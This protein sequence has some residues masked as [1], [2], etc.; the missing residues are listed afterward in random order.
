[1]AASTTADLVIESVVRGHHVYKQ[2]WTPLVG[3]ELTLEREH[4]NIHDCYATTVIKDTMI[5]GRVP[6]QL[7]KAFWNFLAGG[8]LITCEVTGPRKKGKGLEVPCFYKL[9]G[10]RELISKLHKSNLY[11]V[12]LTFTL[13][14][15]L[16]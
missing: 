8:G 9:Q 3:E 15:P 14:P 12:Q 5:V 10:D 16:L 7:S 13:L 4:H 6:R 11:F 1:M 2:I